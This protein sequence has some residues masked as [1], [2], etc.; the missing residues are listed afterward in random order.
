MN[1]WLPSRA[2]QRNARLSP[3]SAGAAKQIM[4]LRAQRLVPA[5]GSGGKEAEGRGVP[6]HPATAAPLVNIYSFFLLPRDWGSPITDSE[7]NSRARR[8]W[9]LSGVTQADLYSRQCPHLAL[10]W[11]FV[12]LLETTLLICSAEQSPRSA[13]GCGWVMGTEQFYLSAQ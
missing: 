11:S 12:W 4:N 13:G 9:F 6:G 10:C 5:S 3:L 1:G 8:S 2:M 7:E